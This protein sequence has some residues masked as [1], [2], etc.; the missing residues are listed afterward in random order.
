MFKVAQFNGW[1]VIVNGSKLV[2]E[3]RKRPGEL[4]FDEGMEEVRSSLILNSSSVMSWCFQVLQ[5]KNTLTRES[6]DD[7]YHVEIIRDKLMRTLSAV[8]PDMV[9]ELAVAVPGYIPVNGDGA[10]VVQPLGYRKRRLTSVYFLEWTT[11]K[12]M[13]T[14]QKIVARVSNRIFV[15][16]PLCAYKYSNPG[17]CNLSSGI[18]DAV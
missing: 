9:D 7:P 13:P 4:S 11:V 14:M 12:V 5:L 6:I 2:D 16:L 8:I 17:E 15:G 1:I 3:V 10:R 18:N